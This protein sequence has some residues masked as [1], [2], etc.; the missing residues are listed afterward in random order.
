MKTTRT[1]YRISKNGKVNLSIENDA[2][3]DDM[4]LGPQVK[5]NGTYYFFNRKQGNQYIYLP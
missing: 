4:Y 5:E 2:L 3:T 1:G